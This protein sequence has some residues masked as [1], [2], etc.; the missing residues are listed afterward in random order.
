M[1]ACLSTITI[2]T[3]VQMVFGASSLPEFPT[4]DNIPFS[5]IWNIIPTTF[6]G[7]NP[8]DFSSGGVIGNSLYVFSG[9]NNTA[10]VQTNVTWVFDLVA[11]SWTV[12]FPGA[13]APEPRFGQACEVV[14]IKGQEYLVL[15]GGATE[16]SASNTSVS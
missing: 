1:R 11:E 7:P 12:R 8:S 10:Y 9:Q 6:Y 15:F 14:V 16:G 3:L 5:N 4:G 2:I 13:L